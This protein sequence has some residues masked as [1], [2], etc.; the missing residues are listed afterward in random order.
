M[1]VRW[2]MVTAE[3]FDPEAP[4]QATAQD[5]NYL[6]DALIARIQRAPLHWHLIV[7]IGQPDDPTDDATTPWPDN[8]EHV[9]VGTLTIDHIESEAPGNCRD[10]N[11]D[12]LVLPFGILNPS[13][14]ARGKRR[15]RAQSRLPAL[16]WENN[17]GT[18]SAI[19]DVF[20]YPALDDGIHDSGHAVHRR[21]HGRFA[22]GLSL[23][24][25][26]P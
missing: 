24:G 9:D 2:S 10:V 3:P 6:F 1:P 13:R 17:Y 18:A 16:A 22:V 12:P 23:A 4:D 15:N 11:F 20:A 26:D 7:T 14:G 21:R 19:H 8:R 25:L 5:E